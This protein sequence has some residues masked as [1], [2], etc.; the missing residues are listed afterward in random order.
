MA[1]LDI[2][3]LIVGGGPVGSALAIDLGW[4][5]ID[6]LMIEQGDGT[7]D[8]PR[9]GIILTRM[10]EFARRWGIVDRIYNC[11]F[12]KNYHL[13]VVYCTSMTGHLL[14][15]DANPSA[16]EMQP[17]PESPEK[18]QRCPQIWFNPLIERAAS[19]YDRVSIHHFRRME[20]F[21]QTADGVTTMVTDLHTG[22]ISAI[23]SKYLVA[24]DG[25]ASVARQQ[26]QVTMLGNPALSFSVNIFIRSPELLRM[27]D[28]GEAERY[29]FVGP[30]GT[31]ANLTVVDGRE[32]WR[33]TIIGNEQMMDLST[34]DPR[35]V[36]E[37]C[38]GR[39]GIPYKIISVKPWR[40]TELTAERMQHGRV[41]LA[42]DA[43]HTMSPTGGFGMS[44]GVA[45]S[46]D[47]G[48]KLEAALRGWAGPH[49]L[50]S[51]DPERQPAA[52]RAASA[53][54]RNFRAWISAVDTQSV[55]DDTAEAE[56][57]RRRIGRHMQDVGRD[58]WDSLGM[59]LGYCYDN[60]P[61]V[62]AD[63]TPAPADTVREY[64]QTS[65]PGSRAPHAWLSDGRS[66]LDLFG[67]G[68][69]LMRLGPNPPHATPLVAAAEVVGMP[70]RVEDVADPAIAT[71]YER[72]L[73]LVRPDGHVAWRGD[74][75][76]QD[77][78]HLVD[79]VRGAIAAPNAGHSTG[80]GTAAGGQAMVTRS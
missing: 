12:D 33:I 55:L 43:A 67:R 46:V 26:L 75:L 68:F 63:G 19:E 53:S 57:T 11:G 32:L 17:P 74:A 24:C 49:L 7:V 78:A 76:P 27:H 58:D 28:K 56:E 73:V 4:R 29:I 6:C 64:V 77:T 61:I 44:T 16:A 50:D 35:A 59:Q 8:H 31:W 9:L 51:Y 71:L 36:V 45:D 37:K 47:L 15:R 66:T 52:M 38:M 25:A 69:V 3:V 30:T 72:A 18:R 14:A 65:R 22:E 70:L 13:N 42:G 79:V 60:S 54:A 80:A 21:E 41:F 1:V 5:G 34:F 39:P 23:K 40:R 10:M 20:S 2:P 48:W 62:V